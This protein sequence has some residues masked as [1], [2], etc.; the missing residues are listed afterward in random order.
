MQV[1]DEALYTCWAIIRDHNV[2]E[3]VA[4]DVQCV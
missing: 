3:S 2:T 1:V 4:V